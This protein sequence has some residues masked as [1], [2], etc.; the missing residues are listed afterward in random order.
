[1]FSGQVRMTLATRRIARIAPLR[2]GDAMET[3]RAE[4]EEAL[5]RH[6]HER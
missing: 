3:V 2:A 1:M 4:A 6:G 5:L